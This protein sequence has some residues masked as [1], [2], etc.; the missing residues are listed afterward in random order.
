LKLYFGIFGSIWVKSHAGINVAI[1]MSLEVAVAGSDVK[2]FLSSNIDTDIEQLL[3][4]FFIRVN[5][6]LIYIVKL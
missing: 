4:Y 3:I 5:V 2:C 6:Q 1:E